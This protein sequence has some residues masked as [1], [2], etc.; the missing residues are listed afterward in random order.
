VKISPCACRGLQVTWKTLAISF[1]VL[2]SKLVQRPCLCSPLVPGAFQH[3]L[4]RHCLPLGSY[5]SDV[6][7]QTLGWARLAKAEMCVCQTAVIMAL[8]RAP[9][10]PSPLAGDWIVATTARRP[11][12][13]R[14]CGLLGLCTRWHVACIRTHTRKDTDTDK[15][16]YTHTDKHTDTC[17]HKCTHRP[18]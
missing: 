11:G 16:T 13:V 3:A 2:R 7:A 4:R 1:P 18:D 14:V 8:V 6:H 12:Q 9:R 10:S 5:G 15:D 17:I